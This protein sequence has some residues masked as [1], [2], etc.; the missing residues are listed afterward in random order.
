MHLK[1]KTII[2]LGLFFVV[3]ALTLVGAPY[4][5]FINMQTVPL[6]ELR[7]EKDPSVLAFAPVTKND[8][9]GTLVVRL[10]DGKEH[11]FEGGARVFHLSENSLVLVPRDIPADYQGEVPLYYIEHGRKIFPLKF[12]YHFGNIINITENIDRTYLAIETV[13]RKSTQFCVIERV[14][15]KKQPPCQQIGV[16]R[17]LQSLWNPG[18]DHEFLIKTSEKE[19]IAFDPW[20]KGPKRVRADWGEKERY[21]ELETIIATQ[22]KYQ[23]AGTESSLYQFFSLV[24]HVTPT[25]RRI[26]LVPPFAQIYPLSDTKHILVQQGARLSVMEYE[27]NLKS[28][29]TISSPNA[30]FQ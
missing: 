18:R 1:R 7:W 22:K 24:L 21:P 30:A 27:N 20:E 8:K 5:L 11:F 2:I 19:I 3:S 9:Q 15:E 23:S 10:L 25:E 4:A 29:I 14:S 28:E 6:S 13:G 17:S 12:A 26:L 16:S